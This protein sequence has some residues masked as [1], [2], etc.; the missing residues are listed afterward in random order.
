MLTTTK[1]IPINAPQG[2][3]SFAPNS[4]S[5]F[6]IQPERPTTRRGKAQILAI[7]APDR[8]NQESRN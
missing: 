6:G 3:G 2:H 8:L 7:V 4:S 1:E 5:L